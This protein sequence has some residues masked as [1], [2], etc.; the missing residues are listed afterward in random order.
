MLFRRAACCGRPVL[1]VLDQEPSLTS[2][3]S[4]AGT[5]LADEPSPPGRTLVFVPAFNE[6]KTV[7]DV[8]RNV[9]AELPSV[10]VLVVD[11]GSSDGTATV[12]R[13]AGARVASIPFN[14]G[15]GA[16]L[17]TGYLVAFRD[18]YQYCAHLDADG[19]HP[20][21]ELRRLLGA[22]WEEDCDLALGSRYHPDQV[23][24]ADGY[25]PTLARR[26]GI[27]LF[28]RLLT[29]TCGTSFTDTTSGL[30]AANRRAIAL[31]AHRYQPDF[32]E[33]ESLQRSVREGL[34]ITEMPVRMLPRAAGT[35]KITATHFVFKGLLVVFV[36]ALRRAENREWM[37]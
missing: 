33:L 14:Q 35:S 10:D 24:L 23:E 12:A 27:S 22:V 8:V 31:F 2:V 1:A 18:G 32:G 26:I 5:A 6:E 37:C 9:R 36:G 3:E 16:A 19:Q 11:D 4:R 34:R 25:R 28:R 7:G 30:R 20:V 21:V 29:L 15:L 13:D 17:H